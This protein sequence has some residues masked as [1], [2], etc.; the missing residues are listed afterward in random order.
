M[1]CLLAVAP[2]VVAWFPSDTCAKSAAV[3][4]SGDQYELLDCFDDFVEALGAVL[5]GVDVLRGFEIA[6]YCTLVTVGAELC[7]GELIVG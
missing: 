6:L 1:I 4:G 7:N 3:A 2:L 5:L